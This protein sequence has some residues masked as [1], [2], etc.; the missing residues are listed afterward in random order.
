[1]SIKKSVRLVDETI[2][3]CHEL[4]SQ[5]DTN[6]S[7][8]INTMAQHYKVFVDECL[9]SLTANE[10]KF[11]YYVYTDYIPQPNLEMEFYQQDWHVNECWLYDKQASDLLGTNEQAIEFVKRVRAWSKPEKLAVIYMARV[12]WGK[13]DKRK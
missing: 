1:M 4:T 3:L 5:G 8:A 10:K 12:Y 9:P 13:L 7:G 11:I 6:W 2:K